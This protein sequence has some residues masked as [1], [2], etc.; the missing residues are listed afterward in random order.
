MPFAA[1]LIKTLQ[2]RVFVEL[3]THSGNSYFSFC[4]GVQEAGLETRCYA[5]DTWAGD[6]HAGYYD[7]TVYSSVDAHN[8]ST[9]PGFSCL[10]RMTFDEALDYFSDGSVDLLHIDG[11]H[12]YDAV[13][14]D[15]D[16]WMPKLS[17]A[18]VVLFHDTNVRERGFGVWRLWEELS[19]RYPLNLE[20]THSHG[21]GVLQLSEG[22][23]RFQ[24]DWLRSEAPDKDLVCQF[25]AAQGR[26]AVRYHSSILELEERVTRLNCGVAER[27]DQ[28]AKLNQVAAERDEQITKLKEMAAERDE[29]IAKLNQMAAEREGQIATRN[30]M[31]AERDG[32]IIKLNEV[33]HRCDAIQTSA[34]WQLARPLRAAESRWPSFTRGIA[35]IPKLAWWTMTFRLPQRLRIRR[36]ATQ[37]IGTG[38]FD[39]QWYVQQ[40]PE[41]VLNGYNPLFHW[42]A[43]GCTEG[44]NPN[45]LFDVG[46]YLRENPD[47]AA[48]GLNPLL[49]YLEV[50]ALEGRDPHPE[51]DSSWYLESYTQVAAAGINP[52]V[53]YLLNGRTLGRRPLPN[54]EGVTKGHGNATGQTFEPGPL[55]TSISNLAWAGDW[56]TL[57]PS[58]KRPAEERVLVIDWKPPTPDRDSGSYRMQMILAILVDAGLS[59]DFVGDREAESPQYANALSARGIRVV[60]GRDACINH[61]IANGRDY[62]HVWIARPEIMERYLPL[63]RAFAVHARVFYDTIDLHWIRLQRGMAFSDN[64]EALRAKAESYYR[65]ELTNARSADV[66]IAI[67]E[68]ERKTL[69]AEDPALKIA[70]VPN[71]HIIHTHVPPFNTRSNLIFVGGFHHRPNVDAVSYFIRDVL[72]IL[73]LQL[74]H[75]VFHIVGSDMP[76]SIRSLASPR[77]NPVGYVADVTP[78]FEQTRVFVAPLRHGAGMKGK[79]G[80]SL[81]YGLPVVTTSIGAEG[82]GLANDRDAMIADNPSDFAAAIY[83]LYTDDACWRRLSAAGQD[84]I[85][86]CYSREMVARTLLPL[87]GELQVDSASVE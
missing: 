35:A 29:Q 65:I 83:R 63:I 50:G 4:Q 80:Q 85:R 13:R 41:I 73:Y 21:L 81:S 87:L 6:E 20:F 2:P 45:P 84:V 44:R 9:Y 72:P 51:F 75:L 27:D 14:H 82:M 78:W 43:T 61:L 47:V 68:G 7:E 11:L 71:I 48:A 74:P 69:M 25:F 79:V 60:L 19:S 57:L 46:W 22:V 77:I 18:A 70:V 42:L 5:V 28:I 26:G 10:L 39:R 76:D 31:L 32:Q 64:P 53:D 3:G 38:L 55:P 62:Q 66:T 24:L 52:L 56:A 54:R 37:L 67:T 8:Q 86:R 17:P 49:H 23:G 15:L 36:E 33:L 12:T 40:N 30:K 59:V 16:S 34:S 1:W 58:R